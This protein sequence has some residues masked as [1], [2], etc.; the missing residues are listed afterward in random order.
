MRVYDPAATAALLWERIRSWFPEAFFDGPF[1]PNTPEL[2]HLFAGVVVLAD[3]I[4]SDQEFFEFE[5]RADAQYIERARRIADDV[6]ARKGFRRR[7]RISNAATA[8]V[9]TLFGYDEPRPAQNA[10]TEASLDCPLLILESETGSGKTEAAILRFAA[11][12]RAGVVDGL[13]FAVPTRAAAK[14]LHVRVRRALDRLFPVKEHVETV[15]AVPGYLVVGDAHPGQRVGQFEV[16]W[17]DE[18]GRGDT[19]RPLVRR[20]RPQIPERY[21]GGRDN[22]PG[23]ALRAQGQMGS[24]SSGRF[25]A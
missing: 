14:Q 7:D 11:L 22:R 4:G 2:P 17:E 12:C 5:P 15:L 10:V 16:F 24:L 21:G 13:Y 3:Q 8:D 1:L 18:P 20:E 6:V 9:K 19:P 25:G 23:A